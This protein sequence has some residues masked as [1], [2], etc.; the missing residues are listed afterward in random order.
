MKPWLT[1]FLL[2]EKK[3]QLALRFLSVLKSAVTLKSSP[4][5]KIETSKRIAVPGC[6]ASGKN[7]PA[8]VVY[9]FSDDVDSG[10]RRV[11]P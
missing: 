6:Y 11:E 2:T 8:V 7:F 10:R 1:K 5:I 9:V 4:L 3:T